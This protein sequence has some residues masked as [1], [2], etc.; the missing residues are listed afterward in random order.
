VF[1]LLRN[2]QFGAERTIALALVVLVA[3]IL[4][5]SAP[6][7]A[8]LFCGTLLLGAAVTCGNVLLP[9]VIKQRFEHGQGPYWRCTPPA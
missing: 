6:S 2:T 9:G 8:A 1:G 4:L 5:R 3:S 7:I